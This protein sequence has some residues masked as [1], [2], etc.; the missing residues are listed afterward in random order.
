[1]SRTNGPPV[2]VATA[3]G[4]IDR[5]FS[6]KSLPCGPHRRIGQNGSPVRTWGQAERA[7]DR[8]TQAGCGFQ[9]RATAEPVLAFATGIFLC[10]F[11]NALKPA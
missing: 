3:A 4:A 6:P 1:M 5:H 11:N 7:L 9:T 2:T 8:D 10:Y